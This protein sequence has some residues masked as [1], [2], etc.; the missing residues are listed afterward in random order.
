MA[1]VSKEDAVIAAMAALMDMS[2]LAS[3]GYLSSASGTVLI[4]T[5]RMGVD[6]ASVAYPGRGLF[7]HTGRTGQAS[8]TSAQ[9]I[10]IISGQ[11]LIDLIRG[12]GISTQ[13]R[14]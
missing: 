9:G 4:S 14:L 3:G 1:T 2:G 12:V 13:G 10:E 7:V 6:I 11:K 8:R 5:R